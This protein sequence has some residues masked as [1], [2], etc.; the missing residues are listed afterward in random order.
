VLLV[1]DG[2]GKASAATRPIH[3][4]T[5]AA[6]FLLGGIRTILANYSMELP[7]INGRS[8]LLIRDEQ[9]Q[10]VALLTFEMSGGKISAFYMLRNPDKLQAFAPR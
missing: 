6:R 8:A 9:K 10:P 3:G 7:R 5:P 2:G 4:R 1:A